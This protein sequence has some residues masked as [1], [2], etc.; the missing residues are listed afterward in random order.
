MGHELTFEDSNQD[1]LNYLFFFQTSKYPLF[2]VNQN[3]IIIKANPAAKK[4]GLK[5]NKN[6]F[7]FVIEI[8]AEQAKQ[9]LNTIKEEDPLSQSVSIEFSSFPNHII[10]TRWNATRLDQEN[11]AFSCEEL[12]QYTAE[13]FILHK[14][15]MKTIF[16]SDPNLIG[17]INHVGHYLF[18][19]KALFDFAGKNNEFKVDSLNKLIEE[20][21]IWLPGNE[22]KQELINKNPSEIELITDHFGNP[23]WFE[24]TKVYIT[25]PF[26]ENVHLV[27]SKNVTKWKKIEK[28]LEDLQEEID[29]FGKIS[30]LS[31]MLGRITFDI[32]N[33]LTIILNYIQ[34]VPHVPSEI[35]NIENDTIK[36]SFQTIE[37][38]IEKVEKTFKTMRTL[39]KQ[40]I[41][42]H[43]EKI[44]VIDILTLS[45]NAFEDKLNAFEINLITQ[46]EDAENIEITC[47]PIEVNL[48][49][50][51]LI[52][53]CIDSIILNQQNENRQIS[54]RVT[55]KD[56]KILIAFTDNGITMLEE[57]KNKIFE[58]FFTTKPSGKGSGISLNVAKDIIEQINGKLSFNSENN[59]TTFLVELP[60]L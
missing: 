37:N 5:E 12:N 51:Y 43:L 16:D 8:E 47:H 26:G 45:L 11:F 9:K 46:F 22:K 58:P 10:H 60:F 36:I 28:K 54:I 40:N 20:G 44:K 2:I 42:Q 38:Y 32:K 35:S 49:F 13:D 59:K 56:K 23:I 48:A 57:N 15:L 33:P 4:Y 39:S 34:K 52:L 41:S 14:G 6:L 31:N 24:N 30:Y 1:D 7:T 19:N 21:E 3:G 18:A 50:R 29:Y 27:I 53:N 25:L 55:K 17:I